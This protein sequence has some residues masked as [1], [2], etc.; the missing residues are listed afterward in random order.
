[1]RRLASLVTDGYSPDSTSN[2]L[3][4]DGFMSSLWD[5]RVHAVIG[6][7]A[8]RLIGRAIEGVRRT[9]VSGYEAVR[10]ADGRTGDTTDRY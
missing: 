10:H 2:L 5:G 8:E 7:H 1:M 6:A 9:I 3:V 4:T